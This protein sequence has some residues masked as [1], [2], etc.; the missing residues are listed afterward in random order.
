M[1]LLNFRHIAMSNSEKQYKDHWIE[2]TLILL[3]VIFVLNF[4]APRRHEDKRILHQMKVQDLIYKSLRRSRFIIFM[5][6][7]YIFF[8]NQNMQFCIEITFSI[9]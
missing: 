6:N 9:C 4:F 8:E 3:G 2:G 7:F 5:Q 1:S